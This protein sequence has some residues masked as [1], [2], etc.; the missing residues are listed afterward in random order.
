MRLSILI[1]SLT[2]TISIVSAGCYGDGA[3]LNKNHARYFIPKYC[4][5]A[6]GYY[7]ANQV[8][9]WCYRMED[10]G[11]GAGQPV[12]RYLLLEFDR[13]G[14]GKDLSNSACKAYLNEIVNECGRGGRKESGDKWSYRVDPGD[15]CDGVKPTWLSVNEGMQI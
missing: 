1:T 3:D 10:V 9:K 14:A 8:W 12:K 15:S 2:T 6:D 5:H 13:N 7:N 11:N 4:E